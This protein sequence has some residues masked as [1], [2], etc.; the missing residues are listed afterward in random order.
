MRK[1]SLS[2][3]TLAVIGLVGFCALSADA[4]PAKKKPVESAPAAPAAVKASSPENKPAAATNSASMKQDGE[5]ETITTT[6]TYRGRLAIGKID[7]PA[8]FNLE[9]IQNFPEERLHPV[10]NNPVN[11]EEGRDF[12]S[13]MDFQDEQMIH[14]WLP[15]FSQNP[16]LTMVG[17]T[18]TPAKDWT[19]SV[20]DQ[21][22]ATVWKIEGKGEPPQ[23]MVWDG[24]DKERGQVA[25]DTVYIPQLTITNREGY[26]RT[27]SGQPAQYSAIRY[28]EKG[29]VILELSSKRL[30]QDKK[31]EFT[32]EGVLLLDKA[33]DIIRES[34]KVPF[35][36]RPYDAESDLARS[37][38]QAI[39]KYLKDRLFISDTQILR[40]EVENPDRRG[41]AFAIV[42]G[43]NG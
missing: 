11:F 38:Q 21:G 25:V 5:I 2:S 19:Y 14:P 24:T 8:A 26:R 12:S 4:A 27:F 9:D 13:M 30:F 42:I 28:E 29:R 31:T 23:N 18:D 32:K 6:G 37:R 7:P 1:N 22:G 41:N 10:L 15:E 36:I 34:G 39:A 3:L 20:I 40:S 17:K 33:M 16:F 43:G 35:T